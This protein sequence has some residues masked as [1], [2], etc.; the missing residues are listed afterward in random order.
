MDA[1]K[2][3][4]YRGNSVCS[5]VSKGNTPSTSSNAVSAGSNYFPPHSESL[6]SFRP[7][8]PPPSA[9][10]QQAAA[11]LDHTP[12]PS[13]HPTSV[14]AMSRLNPRAPDFST[15]LK[16]SSA[17]AV[18]ACYL[19]Q[20]Q[21]PSAPPPPLMPTN[22]NVISFKTVS[23]PNGQTR[24]PFL[25]YAPTGDITHLATLAIG[26]ADLLGP[27]ENGSSSNNVSPSSPQQQQQP[28]DDRKV[29]NT[30]NI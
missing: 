12:V 27:L 19:Q 20:Q 9:Y 23:R 2:A 29:R 28:A 22:N 16:P 15:S 5:P 4:G 8:P 17:A 14:A 30:E 7:P 6:S 18:A 24:W 25:G 1:S 26:Q 10:G 13:F 3:P 21:P 11:E